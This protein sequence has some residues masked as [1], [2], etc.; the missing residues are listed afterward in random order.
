MDHNPARILVVN[1][2]P[3]IT[4]FVSYALQKESYFVDLSLIHI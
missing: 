3:S 1:D 4:E 2:E